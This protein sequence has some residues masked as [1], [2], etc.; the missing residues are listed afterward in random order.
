M[1]C[2]LFICSWP[3]KCS[4]KDGGIPSARAFAALFARR[5]GFFLVVVGLAAR[6]KVLN[7][8]PESALE[9]GVL[10][11]LRGRSH[12]GRALLPADVTSS[13]GG[14]V[15][16]AAAV[17]VRL[18][19]GKEVVEQAPHRALE[20]PRKRHISASSRLSS[21]ARSSSGLRFV[22]RLSARKVLL[23][24]AAQLAVE[25]DVLHHG[26]VALGKPLVF[27]FLGGIEEVVAGLAAR[28]EVLDVAVRVDA[29]NFETSFLLHRLTRLETRG[30]G[31]TGHPPPRR[32]T[33]ARSESRGTA[34]AAAAYQRTSTS[35]CSPRNSRRWS[36]RRRRRWRGAPATLLLAPASPEEAQLASYVKNS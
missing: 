1:F 20:L 35:S 28:Q 16:D 21:A 12:R 4:I 19:L 30:F 17:V 25:L 22:V 7:E 14:A 10:P 31:S 27:V 8:A 29:A 26:D 6:E 36:W 11:A 13:S 2:S 32:G 18:A 34:A 23:D 24:E 3:G 5:G 9:L 33:G 15:A